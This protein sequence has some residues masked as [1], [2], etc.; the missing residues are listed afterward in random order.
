L[1]IYDISFV[2]IVVPEM[3][4]FFNANQKAR[5]YEEISLLVFRVV[6]CEM[7]LFLFGHFEVGVIV[8]IDELN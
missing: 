8:G 3:K 5:L 7:G 2:C 1:Q 4:K 6:L